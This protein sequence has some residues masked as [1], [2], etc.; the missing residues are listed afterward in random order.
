MIL[1]LSC[2]S[3][4]LLAAGAF[5]MV[6]VG[7]VLGPAARCPAGLLAAARLLLVLVWARCWTGRG[8]GPWAGAGAGG[9]A[10]PGC[11]GGGDTRHPPAAPGALPLVAA[12]ATT[13]GRTWRSA[14]A[15][16]PD[17]GP[18]LDLIKSRR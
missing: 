4:S 12:A 2:N 8:S 7:A 6:E 18:T 9:A 15:S 10:D 16:L 3:A 14:G 1:R 5:L 11:G 13:G 17:P